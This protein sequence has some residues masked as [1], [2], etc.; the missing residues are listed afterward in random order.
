VTA[1]TSEDASSDHHDASFLSVFYRTVAAQL[2]SKR[3]AKAKA[4]MVAFTFFPKT[5]EIGLG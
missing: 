3:M 2:A 5:R 1:L 4:A